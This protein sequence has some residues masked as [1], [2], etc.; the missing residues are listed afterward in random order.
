MKI[1]ENKL[2]KPVTCYSDIS[3]T[4]V[5]QTI[6]KSGSRQ[7]IVLN[8]EKPV[9]IISA[10]DIATR[11]VALKK[12]PEKLKAADIMT[13]PITTVDIETPLEKAFLIM[14]QRNAFS[15]PVTKQEKLMGLLQFSQHYLKK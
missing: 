5:A 8:N 10:T 2:T 1:D 7:I 9:G 11:V 15:I 13:V 4:D 12:D 14:I 6:L 3:V